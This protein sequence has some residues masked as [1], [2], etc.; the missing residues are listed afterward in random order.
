MEQEEFCLKWSNYLDVLHGAF[1]SVL[2]SENFTD[3]TLFCDSES[4]KCHRLI[5]SSCSSYFETLFL[6]I[7][8]SHPI[9]IL[10][11]VKFHDLQALVKFMYTGEVTVPPAQTRSLIKLAEMLK[12]NGLAYSNETATQIQ[13]PR[14]PS[15][16][17]QITQPATEGDRVDTTCEN[18]ILA[19]DS[20]SDLEPP[21]ADSLNDSFVNYPSDSSSSVYKTDIGACNS[22][23]VKDEFAEG[24]GKGRDNSSTQ[25]EDDEE[26]FDYGNEN[27]TGSQILE[28]T[29]IA[30]N[31]IINSSG[32]G[33]SSSTNAKTLLEASRLNSGLH[34]KKCEKDYECNIC[35]KRFLCHSL[36]ESHQIIHTGKKSFIC[37]VCQKS[38]SQQCNL[39]RHERLHTGEKPF[40]CEV[41]K[42]CFFQSGTLKQH[43]R[44]HTGERPFKCNICQKRFSRAGSLNTHRRVHT[45]EKPYKC[46]VCDKRFADSSSLSRHLRVH[47]GEKP[48]KCDLCKKAFS[49][50]SNLN[51]HRTAHSRKKPASL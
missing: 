23:Q 26:H 19:E 48:Y 47:T 42:K 40:K 6:G 16:N 13:K 1:L 17:F 8:H 35:D 15:Q 36:L 49:I 34:S 38:F 30:L 9:I 37:G 11:D 44:V 10:K 24:F 5:L 12:V 3:V 14:Y 27:L 46:G 31:G 50:K 7:S 22:L 39:N 43:Q 41:C 28:R 51:C 29:E 25:F 32:V 33:D 2:N 4:I 21:V 45:G 20:S 18:S